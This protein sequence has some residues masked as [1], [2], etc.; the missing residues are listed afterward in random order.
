M[1][2]PKRESQMRVPVED[3]SVV[4]RIFTWKKQGAI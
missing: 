4:L 1:T 3:L 2:L